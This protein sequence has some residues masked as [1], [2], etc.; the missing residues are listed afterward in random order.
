MLALGTM[1]WEMQVAREVEISSRRL[2]GISLCENERKE[3]GVGLSAPNYSLT[4]NLVPCLFFS[5][6]TNTLNKLRK[7]ARAARTQILL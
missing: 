3:R 2:D 1:L 6:T 5:V 4:F 7:C